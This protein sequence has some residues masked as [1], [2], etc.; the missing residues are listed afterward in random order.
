M[1][2]VG[3]N[4]RALNKDGTER[5]ARTKLSPFQ[6]AQRRK[7]ARKAEMRSIGR[8]ILKADPT[9]KGLLANVG[10]AR[11]WFREAVAF[12]T[13]EKVADRIARLQ[14][15]IDGAQAKH[16]TAVEYLKNSADLSELENL[17]ANVGEAIFDLMDEITEDRDPTAEES[18]VICAEYFTPEVISA[19][20]DA[21]DPEKDPFKAHR[22]DSGDS[23]ED[24]GN[25]NDTLD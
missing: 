12:S 18:A 19:L 13:P 10:K 6:K 1:K 24:D 4:G 23:A 7:E 8:D 20:A 25:D 22:R 14:A 16:E 9:S 21:G 17:E 5:A 3:P 11:A 2:K 15:E